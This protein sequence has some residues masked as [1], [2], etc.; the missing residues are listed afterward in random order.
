MFAKGAV[1]ACSAAAR[2]EGVRRGSAGATRRRGA[3]SSRSWRPTRCAIIGRSR[4]SWPPSRRPPD[5]QVIQPGSSPCGRGAARFY[6]GEAAAATVLA[7]TVAAQGV[8]DVRVAVADGAFTAEQAARV[9]TR[10]SDPLRIVPAGRGGCRSS[11][12]CRGRARR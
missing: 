1:V 11:R 5:V 2:A 6:G 8:D 3:R 7:G 4:R 10:A 12:R 9:G